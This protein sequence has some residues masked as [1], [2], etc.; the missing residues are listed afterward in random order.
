MPSAP[1]DR[2][3][4]EELIRHDM[5][6]TMLKQ[7]GRATIKG[8]KITVYLREP[9][10]SVSGYLAGIDGTYWFILQPDSDPKQGKQVLRQHLVRQDG[11]PHLEI[12]SE[13]TYDEE[14]LKNEMD[15]LIVR[16]R[17]WVTRNVFERK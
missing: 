17:T 5:A 8:Q 13:R 14:P 7:L 4:A 1:T 3:P 9:D 12:H 16:F 11:G 10:K 15:V 6:D 2:G